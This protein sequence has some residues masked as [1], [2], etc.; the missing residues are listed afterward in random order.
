VQCSGA[1][2]M[3]VTRHFDV[4]TM[5]LAWCSG[6][7]VVTLRCED[8]EGGTGRRSGV[9]DDDSA[10]NDNLAANLNNL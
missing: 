1:G 6:D 4:R 8:E 9:K 5:R 2:M 3:R 10:T 7:A